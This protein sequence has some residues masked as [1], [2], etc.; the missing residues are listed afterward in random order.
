MRR[1]WLAVRWVLGALAG[2]LALGAV[3]AAVGAHG[4]RWNDRLD[5]LTHLA[6][7]WLA[8]GIVAFALSWFAAS[9]RRA[10]AIRGAAAIAILAACGLMAPDFLRPATP[11]APASAPHQIKLIEFNAWD[12]HSDADLVARWMAAQHPDLIVILEPSAALKA[13][14]GPATGLETSMVDD[15]IV[16]TRRPVLMSRRGWD[17]HLLPGQMFFMNWP[18]LYGFDG[19]PFTLMGVHMGK[20]IPS[21]R[22][23]LENIRLLAALNQ[24]DR[25]SAILAGD[26]NSTQ[27]SFRQRALDEATG[28][29]RRE[30]GIAT[31]PARLPMLRGRSFP[32]PLFPI[33]HIYAGPL[34]RTVKVERGPRLGSDHYPLIATLA[35][36]GPVSGDPRLWPAP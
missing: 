7:I 15:S 29:E 32:A 28:L 13:R 10:W 12:T 14:I 31:W 25:S 4:G 5:H 23:R 11:R 26:F 33:D 2:V 19:R 27:W 3:V 36:V 24:V 30:R 9:L 18:T 6:S 21:W 20:P 34:W 16:A 1:G 8:A 35:W 22:S 17:T